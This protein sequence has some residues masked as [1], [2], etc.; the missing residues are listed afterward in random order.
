MERKNRGEIYLRLNFFDVVV[1]LIA[2]VV[3]GM[4]LWNRPQPEEVPEEDPMEEIVEEVPETAQVRY[5]ICLKKTVKGTGELVKPGAALIDNSNDH[6]VG[7]ILQVRVEAATG[8]ILDQINGVYRKEEIP[9]Y[10]DIYITVESTVIKEEGKFLLDGGS[11]LR[12]GEVIY[13][14]G[15]GYTASGNVYEIERGE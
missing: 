2:L 15:P 13:V 14:K 10:E 3:G 11:V 4:L 12:V 7:E 8:V 6:N 1:I 9:G 5:T